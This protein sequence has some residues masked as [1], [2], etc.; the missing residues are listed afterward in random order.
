M[1]AREPTPRIPWQAAL[2]FAVAFFVFA[3]GGVL[4]S[5]QNSSYVSFWLPGGLF[6]GVLLLVE[7]RS[8]PWF[9]L[10]ALPAT[11]LFDSL[12]GTSPGIALGFFLADSTGALA[13]AWLVR[14][15]LGGKPQLAT[16]K[17]YGTLLVG[18]GLLS[19]LLSATVG[20]ITLTAGGLSHTFWRSWQYWWGDNAMAVSLVAPFVLAWLPTPNAAEHSPPRRGRRLE[21]TVLMALLTWLTWQVLVEAKGINTPYEAEL[22][23]LLLWAGLR[24]GLRGATAANLWLALLTGLFTSQFLKGLTPA[25]IAAGAYI[26]AAQCFLVVCALI[27]LIPTI[28]VQ[29]RNRKVVE[30][31][32][33]EERF[34]QLTQAAFEGIFISENGRVLDANEQGLKMFGYERGELIG[35]AV[36]DLGA[37]ESRDAI[38]EA[39][40]TDQSLLGGHRLRRKDGSLFY[41]EA[42]AKTIRIGDRT[43]RM[44]AL[45]DISE[46]KSHEQEMSRLSRLYAALSQVN[47]A[48]VHSPGRDPLF[49]E[50]CRVLVEFGG[51][52]MAG[53][54]GI[55]P[56]TREVAPLAHSGEAADYLAQIVNEANNQPPGRT[57]QEGK[58]YVC[59][60]ILLDP[61]AHPWREVAAKAGHRS[62]GIFPLRRRNT[63][64][65]V[66]AVGSQEPDFFQ[67]SEIELLKE[68]ALDVSFALDKFAEAEAHRE[69]EEA[70]GA[71]RDFSAA[72]INSLPG[73]F[74]L[75]DASGKF[76]R[77]N[78]AFERVSGRSAAEIAAMHPLDFFAGTDKAQV[79]ARINEVFAKGESSV[80]ADFVSKDGRETPYFFTGIV[81]QIDGKKCL[82]GIG[83]DI[84][85]R[86]QAEQSLLKSEEKFSKAFRASPDGLAISELE[87]GRYIEINEGYCRLYGHRREE[88]IGHTSLEIGLWEDPRDRDRLV[89]QLKATGQA[90]NLEVRTRTRAGELRIIHLSAESMDFG[91]EPCFL[92]VLHDV[93][94]RRQAEQAL[95]ESE[96]KFSKA[97]RTSP[98]VMS[99]V[100]LETDRYLEVNEAH[101]RFF[102]FKR[103][104]VLG[105]SPAELG[106]VANPAVRAQ[107]V[108]QLK[109]TG[110]LRNVEIPSRNRQN[111]LL[112]ML[113]SADLVELGGR[114][115]ILGVSHDITEEKRT[116]EALRKH[117]ALL[118][119]E[120]TE[121]KEAESRLASVINSTNDMIWSIDAASARI[122]MF[123]QTF[124]TNIEQCWGVR[125]QPGMKAKEIMPANVVQEWRAYYAQTIE[126]GE[127]RIEYE[128][129]NLGKVFETTLHSI[130]R[131]GVVTGISVFAKDITERKRA[132]MALRVLN[133]TLEIEVAARTKE[134]QAALVR[135]EAA[136][137]IK[138]AFLATMS[139]ELR[140]PLNSIIGFTGVVLQGLA[141]PLNQEQSKQLGMVR[142]SARHLLELINDVLD[143]SKIE[144]GQLEVRAE[145]FDLGASLARVIALMKPLADKKGLALRFSPPPDLGDLVSD[146]RRVEQILINLLNNAIKFTDT[147]D[148]TLTGDNL[149]AFPLTSQSPAG[150]VVRL[151]VRDTGMGIKP[152]DLATLFQPFRQIDSGIGRQHEGTGLG[153]AICRRL[154]D[155]LGG[156]ISATSEYGG[157]SEFTLTLPRHKPSRP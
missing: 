4:F 139:H 20:A 70:V 59:N 42:R 112:I 30:L 39:I 3:E 137:R 88:M 48:I 29:E 25:E 157:G 121:R 146:Q 40:R 141:G 54:A 99:I 119:A 130:R 49:G 28:V 6:V 138:S 149:A 151:R 113:H 118:E 34:R 67:G 57:V 21:A 97:F 32:Q 123:N 68:V 58:E 117:A 66:M 86:R 124:Q 37:P 50:V 24:F 144:A 31:R 43:L 92:S 13:G 103:A 120:T 108:A 90:R 136:D 44:T 77:W 87:T 155:L 134:L 64:C 51:F 91:G 35:K 122:M 8:W 135:A 63:V 101:E 94:D 7:T 133:K 65:G 93:T 2:L 115:C 81:S 154:A 85:A 11:L 76:L 125:V 82:A 89:S 109:A 22:I 142:T 150:P 9:V 107:A 148:V 102:G 79:A 36:V 17:E 12:K 71:E 114:M 55:D 106:I 143:I 56:T 62:V 73:V 72:V 131:G 18:A 78:K 156:E 10:A 27:T 84:T 128:M 16:L 129:E 61:Q 15:F 26:P 98:D 60:D 95:R 38:A 104:D 14:W 145:P 126:R 80:E 19:P 5:S 147:G 100:D 83:I 140:T 53:I 111:D 110:S 152:A 69:T 105:H 75:Y 45:R 127:L 153:L 46:R 52:T 116:G 23:P 1:T 74:Y 96:E 33:S 132:E 41:A 47:Q